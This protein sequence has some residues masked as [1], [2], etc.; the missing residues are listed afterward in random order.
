[1]RVRYQQKNN[2]ADSSI[3]Q[4][5]ISKFHSAIDVSLEQHLLLFWPLIVRA[6][7]TIS[8]IFPRK[9]ELTSVVFYKFTYNFHYKKRF[10]QFFFFF[11]FLLWDLKGGSEKVR[12]DFYLYQDSFT[13]VCEHSFTLIYLLFQNGWINLLSSYAEDIC[14]VLVAHP[15]T[16]LLISL[17]R[18]RNAYSTIWT[19]PVSAAIWFTA[20]SFS[21]SI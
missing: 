21:R 4:E 2:F 1:M 7:N 6:L 10:P 20:N 3:V 15:M 12:K 11:F 9:I 19:L 17:Q 16:W 5:K 14:F 18:A 8:T 13:N